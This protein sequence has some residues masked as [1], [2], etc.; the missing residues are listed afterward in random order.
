MGKTFRRGDK[1]EDKVK[2]KKYK[3]RK[4]QKRT[5][6]ITQNM[7]DIFVKEDF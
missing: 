2:S 6:K 1:W 5:K 4:K 3:D 7:E